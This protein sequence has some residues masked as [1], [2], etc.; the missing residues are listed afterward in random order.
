MV[1]E[2]AMYWQTAGT[3]YLA[4]ETLCKPV[5]QFTWQVVSVTVSPLLLFRGTHVLLGLSPD[6]LLPPGPHVWIP[7]PWPFVIGP[8][9]VS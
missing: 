2:D 6:G 7:F 9:N 5:C 4:R 1:L 3:S 8:P